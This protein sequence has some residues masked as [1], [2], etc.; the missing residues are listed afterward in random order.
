MK[1]RPVFRRE[2]ASRDLLDAATRYLDDG[3][4]ALALRF[5]AAVEATIKQLAA[6]P[7][8]GSPRYAALIRRP[9]LRFRQPRRFPYLI[10]YVERPE[11]IDVLRVLHASRDIPSTLRQDADDCETGS[12]IRS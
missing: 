1:P 4:E 3:G 12:D 7:G 9:G 2:R 10:F 8:S 5:V 6:R 11:H